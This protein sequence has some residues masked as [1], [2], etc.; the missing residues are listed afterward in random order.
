MA[1]PAIDYDSMDETVLAARARGGEQGAFRAIMQRFNQRLFRVARSLVG[2]EHEAEDVLQEAYLRAFSGIGEFRNEASLMTWLTSI[3]LNEARGR[4]R[5]RRKI[6]NLKVVDEADSTIVYLTGTSAT[7][8][9]EAEAGRSQARRMMERAIDRLPE[10][11]RIVFVLRGIEGCNVEE[12]AAQLGLNPQTVKTRLH[13][14]RRLLRLELEQ[15]FSAGISGVFPF[16]GSRCSR[17]TERVIARLSSE[18]LGQKGAEQ[19]G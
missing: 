5:K 10:D 12:T 13:R 3:T 19:L 16:L 6:V 4:L 8:D 1:E 9:P 17:I 7:P 11:F 14:A 18:E 2:T 15:Q